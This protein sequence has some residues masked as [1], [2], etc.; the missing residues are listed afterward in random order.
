MNLM[1]D[2]ETKLAF[3]HPRTR[4]HAAVQLLQKDFCRLKP[5]TWI[6]DEIMNAFCTLLDKETSENVFPMSSYF[7]SMLARDGYPKVSKWL[8]GVCTILLH[9]RHLVYVDFQIRFLL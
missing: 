7:M 2:L 1:S 9:S 6:N 3:K 5:N 4:G 8:K